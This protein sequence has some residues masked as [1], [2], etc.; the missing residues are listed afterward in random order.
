[1]HS[2][3]KLKLSGGVHLL[4]LNTEIVHVLP[5]YEAP[6]KIRYNGG[7]AS[8]QHPIGDERAETKSRVL[9]VPYIRY[10]GGGNLN[11]VIRWVDQL[12]AIQH[13]TWNKDSPRPAIY[14]ATNWCSDEAVHDLFYYSQVD[15][16]AT[17]QD[18][19]WRNSYV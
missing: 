4:Q 13:E 8:M 19:H 1:M 3:Q 6:S 10:Y 18:L 11:E 16:I 15:A 7:C 17:A 12:D 14:I 2:L 9:V 5:G